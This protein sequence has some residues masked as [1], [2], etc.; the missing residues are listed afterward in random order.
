MTSSEYDLDDLKRRAGA[1]SKNAYAPYSRF[2]VGAAVADGTGRVF[3]GCNVENA[4]YGL[5]MCA[6]RNALATAV[7]EGCVA[8]E[9]PLI[10]IY[11]S[12][13]KPAAPCGACR[14]VIQELLNSDAMVISCC[15]SEE[16][17]DWTVDEM[18]PQPFRKEDMK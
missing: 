14:Q 13:K 11:T 7:A 3:T 4:S 12:G 18:L 8:G 2:R 5:T 9:F 10:V 15:D 17:M 16:Q 1:A 6:E